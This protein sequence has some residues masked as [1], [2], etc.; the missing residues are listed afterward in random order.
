M[1]ETVSPITRQVTKESG[2]TGTS[3]VDISLKDVEGC[4]IYDRHGVPV[5][6][7]TLYQD[8]KSVIVFVRVGKKN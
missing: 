2:D 1:A 6:F 3:S 4:L 5:P 7:Q 8:R